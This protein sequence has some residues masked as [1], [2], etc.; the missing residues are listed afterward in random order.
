MSQQLID[1]SADLT[2]L[3]NDGYD[4][5]IRFGYVIVRNIPYLDAQ[6]HV[7]RG[8]LV[9]TLTLIGDATGAPDDHVAFFA[10]A[11]PCDASG[12]P[13]EKIRHQSVQQRLGDTLVV[14]HSFSSKPLAGRYVDYYEKMTTYAAI[15][16]SPVRAIDPNATA[17]PFAPIESPAAES[18][19]EY[20]DTAS[21]RA[22]INVATTKLSVDKVAVVGVG[23]TGSY[24][25]DLLSKTPVKEIHL[26]DGDTFLQ[27]NAFRSPGAASLDELRTAPNKATYFAHR[28]R[29]M[30]RGIKPHSYHISDSTIGELRQMSFIFLCIDGSETKQTV[31]PYLES[32]GVSFIDVGMGVELVDSSLRGVLRVT[33]STPS[34]RQQARKRISLGQTV[35]DDYGSNIQV[36]DL[37][38]LNSTLAVIK[39]K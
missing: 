26:F 9:S 34:R 22:G 10:G 17:R 39:W 16:S 4:V 15:V 11:Y 31:I 20:T 8:V 7:R 35:N 1:R 36:A 23:G 12:S 27:H 3:R 2:R 38:A 33:S 13:L 19:F 6:K 18:V 25:L 14:D 5:D 32:I 21:S 28:Y 30:H 24:V 37:N 29:Q